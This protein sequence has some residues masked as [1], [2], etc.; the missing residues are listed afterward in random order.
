M[1][2]SGAFNARGKEIGNRARSV[3]FGEKWRTNSIGNRVCSSF[4]VERRLCQVFF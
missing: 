4:L 3:E 1:Y 2:T